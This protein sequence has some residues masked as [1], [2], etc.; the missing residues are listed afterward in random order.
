MVVAGTMM[1]VLGWWMV[2]EVSSDSECSGH[3]GLGLPAY[4]AHS[5]KKLKSDIKCN[6]RKFCSY[7]ACVAI[8]PVKFEVGQ[9]DQDARDSTL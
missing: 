2:R 6:F 4:R 8:E 3:A 5:M 9:P 1:L 7:P